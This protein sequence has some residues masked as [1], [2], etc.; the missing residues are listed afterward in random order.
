ML[1]K[2]VIN[3]FN[4]L[5]NAVNTRTLILEIKTKELKTEPIFVQSCFSEGLGINDFSAAHLDKAFRIPSAVQT[6]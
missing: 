1:K 5:I 3:L 6:V 2:T 4:Q